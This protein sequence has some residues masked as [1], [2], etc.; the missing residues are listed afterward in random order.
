MNTLDPR[1]ILII[2]DLED[3]AKLLQM[4]LTNSGIFNP[5]RV[6]LSA[7]EAITYLEGIPPYSNRAL[8]PLPTVIFIDLKLPGIHGFEFLRWLKA[9]PE[10]KN[11]FL[12]VLSAA[13]DLISVQTAYALGANSFLIKPCRAADL[14]N[15]VACYPDFWVRSLGLGFTPKPEEPPTPPPG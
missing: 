2:E 12:V 5:V 7:E 14:E 11:I 13:G 6:A 9:H 15:L 4:L 10:L 8:Y 1:T 3:D